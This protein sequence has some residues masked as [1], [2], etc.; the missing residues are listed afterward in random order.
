MATTYKSKVSE[1]Q[2]DI[3]HTNVNGDELLHTFTNEGDADYFLNTGKVRITP[4]MIEEWMGSDN[5]GVEDFICLL[6]DIANGDYPLDIFRE[7]VLDFHNAN[8]E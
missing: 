7:D 2:W 1:T 5:L 8:K 4:E 3:W 6:A